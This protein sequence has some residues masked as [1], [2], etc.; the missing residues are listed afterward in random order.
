VVL[1]AARAAVAD[2]SAPT[3]GVKGAAVGGSGGGC[4]LMSVLEAR[5]LLGAE[6]RAAA[7][8]PDTEKGTEPS[9]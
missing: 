5:A 1:A 6:E 2:A 7:G 9:R 4:S 3:A 8:G